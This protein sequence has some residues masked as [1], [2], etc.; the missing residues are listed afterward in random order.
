MQACMVACIN[1]SG[2]IHRRQISIYTGDSW[3]SLETSGLSRVLV[4]TDTTFSL[5][6]RSE[7]KCATRHNVPLERLDKMIYKWECSDQHHSERALLIFQTLFHNFEAR[8]KK[9]HYVKPFVIS[10]ETIY[11]S[12]FLRPYLSLSVYLSYP[13]FCCQYCVRVQYQCLVVEDISVSQ[14]IL[15]SWDQKQS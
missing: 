4:W 5:W 7:R 3:P 11:I 12:G 8:L 1:S 13:L 9:F 10:L 14:R 6:T 2:E 15:R